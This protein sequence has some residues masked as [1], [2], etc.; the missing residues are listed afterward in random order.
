MNCYFSRISLQAFDPH[1]PKE[2]MRILKS[3]DYALHQALWE[4]FPKEPA[5]TRDFLYRQDDSQRWPMFYLLSGRAPRQDHEVLRVETKPYH[6][7]LENGDVLSF[8]LRANPVRT[9]KI[10]GD[11]PKQRK[12]DDVVMHLKRRLAEQAPEDVASQAELA[13]EAGEQWLQRQARPHG[14]EVVSVRADNYRQLRLRARGKEIRLSTLDFT[15]LL[16]VADAEEFSKA[17]IRGIGPAKA[18]GCGLMLV[19]RV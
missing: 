3:D 8:S 14:F 5:A 16:R 9:R 6:P 12:R 7:R 4:L 15:G 17:L 13:Q 18:F 1:R 19:R 11:N 2:T 10:G